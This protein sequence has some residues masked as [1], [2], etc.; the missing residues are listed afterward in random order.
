[1][2]PNKP[3]TLPAVDFSR[4]VAVLDTRRGS[5]AHGRGSA[6]SGYAARFPG[7]RG[8]VPDKLFLVVGSLFERRRHP[9]AVPIG[10]VQVDAINVD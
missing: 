4:A 9:H 5:T 10:A 3:L 2:Q 7:H 6:A 8:G 1:M